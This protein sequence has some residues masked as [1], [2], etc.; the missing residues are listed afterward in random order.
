MT[1]EH[2]GDLV[3]P[4]F[5]PW[6]FSPSTSST[7]CL[8]WNANSPSLPL[9]TKQRTYNNQGYLYMGVQSF[10][11]LIARVNISPNTNH[12]LG[13][14]GAYT[15]TAVRPVAHSPSYRYN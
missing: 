11:C 12:Y 14:K 6:F 5:R 15:D 2:V 7:L 4:F 13:R 3:I 9:H 8:V 1:I 10:L